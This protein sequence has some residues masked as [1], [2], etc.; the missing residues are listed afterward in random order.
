MINTIVWSITNL[1][2]KG[3][4]EGGNVFGQEWYHVSKPE[5]PAAFPLK[6]LHLI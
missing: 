2:V 6:Q 3:G 1:E 4:D 5:L